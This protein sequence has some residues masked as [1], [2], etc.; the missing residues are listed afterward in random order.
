MLKAKGGMIW[1]AVR[2]W[3]LLCFPQLCLTHLWGIFSL[4]KW[5]LSFLFL[6]GKMYCKMELMLSFIWFSGYEYV[7]LLPSCLWYTGLHLVRHSVASIPHPVTVT[8]W[9][10]RFPSCT[11]DFGVQDFFNIVDTYYNYSCIF[12]SQ[13]QIPDDNE[14]IQLQSHTIGVKLQNAMRKAVSRMT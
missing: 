14:T 10:L 6:V 2:T 1:F 12:L 3:R 9:L 5:V 8:E 13:I 4:V 11:Y 7:M